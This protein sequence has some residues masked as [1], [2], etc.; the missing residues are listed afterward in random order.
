MTVDAGVGVDVGVDA[1]G[2]EAQAQVDLRLSA[3]WRPGLLAGGTLDVG[4]A[5]QGQL[6][7]ENVTV[8]VSMGAGAGISA[9]RWVA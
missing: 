2:V 8:D 4:V 9:S 5:N 6:T 7:A 1:G 3:A